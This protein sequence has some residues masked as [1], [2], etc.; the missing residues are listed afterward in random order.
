MQ[1]DL[2]QRIKEA[3]TQ[4][5]AHHRLQQ[6]FINIAAHELRNPIQPILSLS[7]IVRGSEADEGK[8][9]LL[10]VV[11]RNARRLRQLTEDVLDVT[12]IESNRSEERRVGKEW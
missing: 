1:T 2:Y 5:E 10:D 3:N 4:L 12:R 9:D 8:K 7:E 6:E 11:V